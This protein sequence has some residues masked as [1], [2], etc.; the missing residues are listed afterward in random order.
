MRRLA[1][2]PGARSYLLCQALSI[3]GDT[4]LW[5]ALAVWVR[6]LTG[7]SAQAGLTF[8]F[9][10]VASLGGPLL[11]TVADRYRRRPLLIV[12]NTAGG[13]LTLALLGVRGPHQV[14]LIFAVMFGYGVVG[15]LQSAAQSGLLHTLL[16]EDLLGDAAGAL[17]TV[18]EGLRVVAPILGVGLFTLAGGHAVAVLDS[19]TF[20]APVLQLLRMRVAEPK[21]VRVA[22]RLR[23]EIGEG[24][25]HIRR[26]IELRQMVVALTG[27]ACVIGF[28]E[29]AVI[30]VVTDGLHL[31][32]SWLGPL[33]VCMGIGALIG[34][35]TVAWAMRR[36]GE[37]R[38]SAIGMAATGLGFGLQVLPFA[39]AVAVALV[40][41]GFGLPWLIAP[42]GVAVQ[43]RTPSRLQGRTSATLDVLFS[44]PQSISIAVGAGL[45]AVVG[46]R[47]LLV[48]VFVV[49][50]AAGLWLGTR[51]EQ[52]VSSVPADL[53][54]SL[55]EPVLIGTLEA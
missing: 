30:A 54:P 38:T 9:L 32:A 51:R 11:G 4:S 49:M 13:L 19:L 26:T 6:A 52:R 24:L 45:L 1:Q 36:L 23:T 22:Q 28:L 25:A 41:A 35:P 47:P 16:P 34:G 43:R 3:A 20:A 46:F 39:A 44:T 18:R 21:P 40:I 14:W 27:C 42:V 33:E 48:A 37:G 10:A 12:T 5:L 50:V 15:S 8:F 2:V 31:S 7:S 53:E 17:T 29:P 55:S